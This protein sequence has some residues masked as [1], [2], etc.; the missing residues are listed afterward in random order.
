M[1]KEL[2]LHSLLARDLL[3]T[4]VPAEEEAGTAGQSPKA[5]GA[6]AVL[7]PV[8]LS[9][10]VQES[11]QSLLPIPLLQAANCRWSLSCCFPPDLENA[12]EQTDFRTF[13]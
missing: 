11:L 12:D 7:F 2:S 8:F 3:R 1:E 6:R 4:P 13:G 9:P 10:R 5:S